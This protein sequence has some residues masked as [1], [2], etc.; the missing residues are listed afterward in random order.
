MGYTSTTELFAYSPLTTPIHL[1]S[2]HNSAAPKNHR[3]DV[4]E[5]LSE[6]CWNSG[7]VLCDIFMSI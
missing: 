1:P 2:G 6:L 4:W 7:Q 5:L 3:P